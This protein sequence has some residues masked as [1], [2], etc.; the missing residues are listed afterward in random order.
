LTPV[1]LR[2]TADLSPATRRAARV[3]VDRSFGSDFSDQD[4]D[5]ALGGLHALVHD[6][7]ELVAHGAVVQRRLLHGGRT[8]R[9][10][11]VEAV[12]VNP[13]LRRRG[14]ASAVMAALEDVVRTAYDLG[15]L[16][17]TDDGA[18]LYRSRGWQPWRGTTWALTPE[19]RVRTP[20]DD[21]AVFVLSASADLD[22]TGELTCDWRDGDLW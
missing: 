14:L 13:A 22:V 3:L 15:A 1:S 6:G 19:G 2:H 11:Y 17:A 8:L 5:H 7:G 16:S 10:G 4:W 21:D 12:A 9:A 20:E 18:A